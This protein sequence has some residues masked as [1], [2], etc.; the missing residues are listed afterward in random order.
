MAQKKATRPRAKAGSAAGLAEIWKRH[1]N[2][3]NAAEAVYM[4]L[5]EAILHGVLP[6]GRPLGEIPLAEV[7]GRSRTPIREAILRLE[8]EKLAVRFSRRGLVV[9]Q[10]T[11]EEVLEVYAVREMLDGFS[12]RLAALGIMP[13]ELDRLSWL[14]DRLRDAAS[15]GNA[16][17]M[18]DL[19]IEFHE[20]VCQA[21]R[22]SLLLEF[23]KR[24]HEWVRRFSDTT[25]SEPGRGLEAVAEHEALLQAIRARD[26]DAAERIARDHMGRARQLRV[27]MLQSAAMDAYASA[28]QTP[29]ASQRVTAVGG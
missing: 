4:T 10:I 22:N 18:I 26:P 28:S 29:N 9:A 6:A 27:R 23:V 24:I 16:S 19:N 20:A 2:H 12:A 13:A 17:A 5:R 11:R 25:M 21:S 1:R 15:A 7:F 8:A 3:Y 14:N